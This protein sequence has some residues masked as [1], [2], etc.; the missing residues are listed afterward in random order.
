MSP[1]HRSAS[2]DDQ[3]RHWSGT[4]DEI[5]RIGR[6]TEELCANARESVQAAPA[7]GG[8][9]AVVFE[10][11]AQEGDDILV[12]RVDDLLREADHRRLNRIRFVG[13]ESG[14]GHTVIEVSINMK[15]RRKFAIEIRISSAD[16]NWASSARSRL[17]HEVGAG[18]SR[19]SDFMV[20]RFGAGLFSVFWLLLPPAAV[21]SATARHFSTTTAAIAA[22]GILIAFATSLIPAYRFTFPRFYLKHSPDSSRTTRIIVNAIPFAVTVLGTLYT[23]L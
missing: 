1:V 14:T 13:T 3:W 11:Q 23:V 17:D 21:F 2:S 9:P 6:L 22:L 18:V 7:S 12:G 4:I 16:P 8:D 10:A 19:G 15:E 20:S 5:K